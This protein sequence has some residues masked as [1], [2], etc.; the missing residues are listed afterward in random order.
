MGVY[1]RRQARSNMF[2]RILVPVD[3]SAGSVAALRYAEAMA[4]AVGIREVRAVH[5]FTPDSVSAVA[6]VAAVVPPAV[7]DLM[8]MRE[9]ALNDF[10]AE[11]PAPPGVNRRGELL[12]GIPSSKIVAASEDSDLLVLG[13]TGDSDVLEEVFGSIASEVVQ[14]AHCPVLLVPSSAKF[15]DYRHILY[16]SNSLSLS[17]Q[18]VLKLMD[19][20]EIFRARIHFVHVN[21]EASE[22]RREREK[23]FAPLFNNP[24]P[25]FA[26]EIVELS[27][28]SVQ[29]G[30]VD[31]L[32]GTSIQLAVMVT[33]E[34]GFWDRL[35]HHSNTRQMVLHPEV[36]V[37]I[38]RAKD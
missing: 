28:N 26:F 33:Q 24:D 10:L 25:E 2:S 1:I 27:A 13:A 3:F 19:F 4:T 18:A 6:D 9:T 38:F 32:R 29:E 11:H 5:V 23:L 17:R 21:D 15:Q 8:D 30:L 36:P 35:F 31:Y 7:G 12:L 14:K 16:A 20:N 37:L 22:H 34:R